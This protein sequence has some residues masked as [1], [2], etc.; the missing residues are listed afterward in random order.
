MTEDV[1]ARRIAENND[2]FRSANER[3]ARVAGEKG[4]G[5]SPIPF[6]CECSDPGCVQLV[7]LTLGDYRRVRDND[8]WFLHARGHEHSVAGAIRPVEE[9]DGWVLVE[10]IGLA[11]E[12]VEKL[13]AERES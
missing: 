3:I 9:N 8:R 10:K 1:A 5:E 12:V 4:L 7:S 11:G 6:V 13:A 2:R